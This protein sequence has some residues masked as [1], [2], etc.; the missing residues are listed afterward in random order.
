[1][2]TL[3]TVGRAAA[4]V[5]AGFLLL[6]Q[7][8][9]SVPRADADARHAASAGLRVGISFDAAQGAA[10]MDGRMLFLISTD[11]S[12]EP[13][14]QIQD[15]TPTQQLFGV[16]V[17]GLAPGQE[18]M[19]DAEVLGYPMA[20]LAGIKA[21]D[22]WV[23]G[24]LHVYTTYTRADGHVVKLPAGDRGEGQQW[25]S[26]PGNLYSTPRKVHLDPAS[27]EPVHIVL[28]Q[29]IAPIAPVADT[30]YHKHV[31]IL[32]E[33]LTKFW[34]TPTYLAA[35]IILPEGWATHPAAH[36]PLA[37][38]HGHFLTD[39]SQLRDTPA[40][41]SL[42]MYNLDSIDRYCPNGHEAALCM[43]WGYP[44]FQQ[45]MAY[46]EFKLW[47]GPKFPRVI[48]VNF[49]HPNQ[50]YDD[51]YAVN[52]EN[53]GPYG[54]AIM[55]EMI[56]YLEKNYR[57]IGKW[58][59]AVYGGSTG[60]WEALG[61]QVKYPDEFNGMYANCPDPIDFHAFTT[62]N[63]YED[64]NAFFAI[65]PWRT[66]P[67]PGERD[68]MG[69]TRVTVEQANTK[70]L[71]I[72][73]HSRSGGQWDIWEAVYSPVGPDGYPQRIF[74]KRTG[75]I[76]AAGAAYWKDNYDL[77]N[78]MR[79]D[80]A[81][82]GPKLQGKLHFNVGL[83]DNFFLNDAVYYAQDLLQRTKAPHSDATFDYGMRDEHCWSGD[84]TV[85]NAVS[86]LTYDARFIPQM[87]AHWKKTAPKGADVS[88]W[89]Y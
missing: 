72:G 17:N 42:P 80:W 60:G 68:Y 20:S 22:Y 35:V 59:R 45:E 55:Y 58:A 41:A 19:F 81:T 70:E 57:G 11:S 14:F 30:K 33:R 53:L 23:Q 66:T 87:A 27:L 7:F 2:T 31:R 54:D 43:K 26:A 51:S 49:V 18:A 44:R 28:D 73:T 24:L 16:D 13:R 79:R 38:L 10:P 52:S 36:Y 3:R 65:G 67:R 34:G 85:S 12:E 89:N 47:T 25:N 77:V 63:I 39:D 74:D 78:I 69:R 8:S 84:H 1:M 83:S 56:P 76:D 37:I 61:V 40:D 6:P 88:S 29:K 46:K 48:K 15:A 32:S 82:L 9:C 4:A 5:G 71:V 75:A 21:G 64:K 62:I 86:R 50:Y